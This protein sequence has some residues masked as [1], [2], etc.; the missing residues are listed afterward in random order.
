ME[1]VLPVL[2]DLGLARRLK[3]DRVEFAARVL[4]SYDVDGSGELRCGH[5]VCGKMSAGRLG[6]HVMILQQHNHTA[7]PERL[8]GKLSL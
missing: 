1:E 8:E 2:D 7:R 3:S 6:S 5:C 4:L